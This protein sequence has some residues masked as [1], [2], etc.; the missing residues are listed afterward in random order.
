[1]R[2]PG[3]EISRVHRSRREAQSWY[4]TL[5]SWYDVVADPFERPYRSMGVELLGAESG[6]QIADIGSG[7]GN[8]LVSIARSVGE[9]GQV[10]GLDISTKMCHVAQKKATTAGVSPQVDIV[11]GDA[12][13]PPLRDA[14]LDAI[15]MSFTLELFD[16][17]DIPVVLSHCQRMLRD[18]GRLCVVALSKRNAGF[19][20]GLY[21][22]VHTAAPQYVDCRPIYVREA[23]RGAEFDVITTREETMWGLPLELVLVRA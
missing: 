8:A 20:T 16:T 21:E 3:G 12:L 14:S 4:D 11:C 13:S 7:T 6:E 15:F 10:V 19:V 18:G 23:L 9:S 2:K 22:R 1:M 5:S 17:P